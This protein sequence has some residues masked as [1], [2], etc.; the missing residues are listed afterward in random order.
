MIEIED[1]KEITQR[2]FLGSFAESELESALA[3]FGIE[4]TKLG[5]D[6]YDY[7]LELYGVPVEVRLS[8]EVQRFIYDC[9]FSK[10]YINHEDKWETHYSWKEPFEISKGWRVS[11]PHKREDN[12]T[13]ILV[14]EEV[15]SWPQKWFKSGYVKIMNQPVTVLK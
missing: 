10:V 4:F 11:Y 6:H 1:H 12:N 9:G 3:D 5:W 13:S 7:S 2:L 15:T 14:E 8:E